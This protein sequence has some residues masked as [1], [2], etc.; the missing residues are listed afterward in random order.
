MFKNSSTFVKKINKDY[1]KV[2][3]NIKVFLKKK[4]KKSS[5]IVLKGTKIYQKMKKKSWLSIVKN[6]IK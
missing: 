4:K 1:K 6:I 3:K 5:K 2:R